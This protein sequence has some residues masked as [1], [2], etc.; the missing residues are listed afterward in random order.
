ML[1]VGKTRIFLALFVTS[2]FLLQSCMTI[3]R[4]RTQGIPVTSH[5]VG[6]KII[7]DGEEIGN[8]PVHLELNR[9]KSH[10]IRIEKQG[11]N[12]VEIGITRNTSLLM[13]VFGNI[14]WG[15]VGASLAT[16]LFSGEEVATILL[17]FFVTGEELEEAAK[18]INTTGTL[19]FLAG[20][21]GAILVDS[22]SGANYT[23][24]PKDLIVTLTKMG[25][26]P[27]TDVILIDAEK[28]Q[29]I[30]WIRIKYVENKR[31]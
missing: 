10:V 7:V 24:T 13:S 18:K 2:V 21:G 28:F 8:T 11:Y 27:G 16:I 31:N 20:W 14:I 15:L 3:I 26:K 19:G 25:E 6:A 22:L 17:P 9:K 4:G 1:A 23:L 12:P 29:D 30:K 5:P